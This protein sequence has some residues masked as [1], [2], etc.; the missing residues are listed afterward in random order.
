MAKELPVELQ[1]SSQKTKLKLSAKAE[2]V[3]NEDIQNFM[4]ETN[5]TGFFNHLFEVLFNHSEACIDYEIEKKKQQYLSILKNEAKRTGI[6]SGDQIEAIA[7]ALAEADRPALV[8]K[9]TKGLKEKPSSDKLH[10]IRLSNAAYGM[11][12]SGE[13]NWSNS[14]AYRTVRAYLEAL[15]ESYAEKSACERELLFFAPNITQI[16]QVLNAPLK[17][18]NSLIIDL[19]SASGAAPAEKTEGASGR[20][21]AEDRMT[22]SVKRYVMVPYCLESDKDNNYYY[23]AGMSRPLG[24]PNYKLFPT[25]FRISRIEAV[26][27]T[28]LEIGIKKTDA[29]EIQNRIDKKGIQYIFEYNPDNPVIRVRLTEEGMKKYRKILHNRPS[30]E[31]VTQDQDGYIY[32]DFYQSTGQILYYFMQFGKEAVIMLPGWLKDKM[33]N[34]YSEAAEAYQN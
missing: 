3:V 34:M 13:V 24:N 33:L 7:A 11:L 15:V 30:Y 19:R 20:V 14:G 2:E 17:K 27:L 18:R 9:Y 10:I 29:E 1:G 28:D 22:G 12:Y 16:Q 21:K 23:L 4:L 26:K 6:K 8:Y 31:T 5:M 25:S 32:M